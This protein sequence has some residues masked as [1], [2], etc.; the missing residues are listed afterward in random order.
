MGQNTTRGLTMV[1]FDPVSRTIT[2]G[3]PLT[4]ALININP[5]ALLYSNGTSTGS[6]GRGDA[7]RPRATVRTRTT[8]HRL[9][10]FTSADSSPLPVAELRAHSLLS[11]FQ[12]AVNAPMPLRR[13]SSQALHFME[14]INEVV[15][16]K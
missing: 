3:F 14:I 2:V 7:A 13:L 8:E 16:E 4:S 1:S 5:N 6:C 10:E 12:F 15:F 9:A 11:R